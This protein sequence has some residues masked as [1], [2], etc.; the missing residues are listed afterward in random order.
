MFEYVF[1][2]CSSLPHSPPELLSYRH[3]YHAQP[4]LHQNQVMLIQ[5]ELQR[6]DQSM[7]AL[8]VIKY[9]IYTLILV[10]LIAYI[11][12]PFSYSPSFH[13]KRLIS[14]TKQVIN[15][16]LVI[17]GASDTCYG[18]LEALFTV[19]FLHFSNVIVISRI[20]LEGMYVK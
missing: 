14:Q 3:A 11:L 9:V 20:G 16:R 15:T 6:L 18:L 13:S 2:V 5:E 7:F 19:P 12:F 10:L 17:V 8:H 4:E 1:I